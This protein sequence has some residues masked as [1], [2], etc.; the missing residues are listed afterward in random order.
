MSN[1]KDKHIFIDSVRKL[2]DTH[3]YLS[4]RRWILNL[5]YSPSSDLAYSDS[6]FILKTKLILYEF[7]K[8]PLGR[9]IDS[10]HG[11]GLNKAQLRIMITVAITV[12]MSRTALGPTQ[13]PIQ[14][15]PGTPSLGVKRPRCEAATHL[16]LVPRSENEW[17]YTS[18]LQ[19]AF[20]AWCLVKKSTGTTLPLSLSL[21]LYQTATTTCRC[22]S[23]VCWC[24]CS[25]GH[26][27]Y[28]SKLSRLLLVTNL[29]SNPH[30]CR[31]YTA[32]ATRGSLVQ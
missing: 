6:E 21:F 29:C 9:G 5:Y 31:W 13:P 7:N 11:T 30:T 24:V 22:K 26:S 15:V 28:N 17:S 23:W 12:P 10:S 19:H 3:S 20:M 16:H 2:L 32:F 4:F 25:S 14:W 1:T 18:T 27:I 8:I